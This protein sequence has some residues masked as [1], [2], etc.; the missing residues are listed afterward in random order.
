VTG[1]KRMD[2]PGATHFMLMEQPAAFNRVLVD[3]IRELADPKS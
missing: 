1:N 3:F 2:F